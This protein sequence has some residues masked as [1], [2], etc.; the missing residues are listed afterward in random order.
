MS[1][2]ATFYCLRC[3]SRFPL[4]YDPK[5]VVER[6]CPECGSN[7]VRLETPAAAASHEAAKR[8]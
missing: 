4:G 5:K 6:S 3:A 8:H 2:Q 1:Q 7:S